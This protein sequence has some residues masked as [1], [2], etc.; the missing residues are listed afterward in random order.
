MSDRLGNLQPFFPEGVALGK[1]A[2]LGM[3]HGELTTRLHSGQEDLTEALAASHPVEGHYGC[4]KPGARPPIVALSVVGEAEVVVCQRLQDDV[5]ASR[6]ERE[7]ALA[8]GD[9]L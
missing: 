1:R 6:G 4:P 7:G 9:G 3:A 5:P 8:G 2:Q